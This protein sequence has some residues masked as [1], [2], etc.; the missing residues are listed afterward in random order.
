MLSLYRIFG[1]IALV[2]LALMDVP[3]VR[4]VLGIFLLVAG[5]AL[6]VGM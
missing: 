2:L 4:I 1:G 6:L 5:V 3:G